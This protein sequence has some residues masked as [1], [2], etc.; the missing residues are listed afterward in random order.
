MCSRT[1]QTDRPWACL[2]CGNCCRVKGY[3]RLTPDDIAALAETLE[4]TE[5]AFVN[6]YT[7]LTADR[8]GLSL[9][10]NADGACV[11][12]DAAG[13][14]RM[15]DSKP[16]QCRDFPIGWNFSGYE[17]LCEAARATRQKV[18]PCERE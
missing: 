14:C 5:P 10:E 18:F 4:M 12:L 16:A 11:F 1:P 6:A 2:R 15:N 17:E 7:R 9:I 3:V 8:R 13:T